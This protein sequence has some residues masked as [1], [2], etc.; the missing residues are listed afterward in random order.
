MPFAS[1]ERCFASEPRQHRDL[2]EHFWP[3]HHALHERCRTESFSQLFSSAVPQPSQL[4]REL[5]VQMGGELQSSTTVL[6][7]A[8]HS[9]PYC[10]QRWHKE[11]A[12]KSWLLLKQYLWLS[13]IKAA[14][15]LHPQTSRYK[16]EQPGISFLFLAP[17]S[18]PCS[19]PGCWCMLCSCR[20]WCH[21]SKH[22][23]PAVPV[24]L[25]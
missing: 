15:R 18:I 12:T 21:P 9:V 10:R 6:S 17:A 14:P 20:N 1:Q 25:G 22:R 7:W 2:Q 23:H 3:T 16:A 4:C 24:G 19:F 13:V 11:G 5:W 8:S